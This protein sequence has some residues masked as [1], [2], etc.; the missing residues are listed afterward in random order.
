MWTN[1]RVVLAKMVQRVSTFTVAIDAT[2]H[3]DIQ[4]SFAIKVRDVTLE[5]S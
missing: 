2:A 5:A 1:V 3:K 4:E